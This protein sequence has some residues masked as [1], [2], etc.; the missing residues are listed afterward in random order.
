M[1]CCLSASTLP[2]GGFASVA[3]YCYTRRCDTSNRQ[4]T[5]QGPIM[6]HLLERAGVSI[7]CYLQKKASQER[8][9]VQSRASKHGDTETIRRSSVEEESRLRAVPSCQQVL[10]MCLRYLLRKS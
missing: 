4:S 3:M 8:T 1:T 6:C 5:A 7:F 9:N 2:G 10:G